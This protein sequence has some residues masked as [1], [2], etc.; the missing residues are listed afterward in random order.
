V[1]ISTNTHREVYFI[2]DFAQRW[3]LP[4]PK[5]EHPAT[6]SSAADVVA[7]ARQ[8]IGHADIAGQDVDNVAVSSLTIGD[9]MP[10]I[11][12]DLTVSATI[13]N[14]GRQ[15]R[16]ELPVTLRLFRPGDRG[17]PLELE[18]KLVSI[19]AQ[20][21]LN[22]PFVLERQNRFQDPNNMCCK[23][24]SATTTC[25]WTFAFAGGNSSR[26]DPGRRRQRQA[27]ARS[28]DASAS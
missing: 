9:A 27:I 4:T 20:S 19:P 6:G 15:L 21:S 18:T 13:H 3:P 12:T 10:L 7:I 17:T 25:R 8:R 22:V 23:C 28:T 26:H 24:E 2:S 16:E 5:R 14:H 1:K 11:N